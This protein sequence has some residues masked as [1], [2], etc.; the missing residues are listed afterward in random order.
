MVENAPD[1]ESYL[2]GQ[3]AVEVGPHGG[4]VPLRLPV[5]AERQHDRPDL[6]WAARAPAG[7]RIRLHV[8]VGRVTIRLHALTVRLGDLVVPPQVTVVDGDDVRVHTFSRFSVLRLGGEGASVQ[9]LGVEAGEP[10]DVVID[11]SSAADPLEVWLSPACRMELLSVV[12]DSPVE[13]AGPSGGPVWVHYGSSISHGM[14][15]PPHLP[16]P[17]QVARSTGWD[18]RNLSFSG[19][20]QLDPFAGRVVGA[21]AA[22]VVTAKIGINVVNADVMRESAFLP[23]VHGFVDTVRERLPD[24]P[25]VLVS[26]ISCPIHEDTPGPVVSDAGRW[27]TARRQVEGDAGA[28][29]L[30]RTRELLERVVLDRSSDDPNLHH[31]DGRSL[32]GPDDVGMLGDDLHPDQA[33]TDLIADR[34]PAALRGALGGA[35][36]GAV[37]FRTADQPEK[38]SVER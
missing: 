37:P 38:T 29:T 7:V 31:L 30:R 2:V 12:A 18:L 25:I 17:V 9:S 21:I 16:W 15:S 10:E 34:F 24:V 8:G 5:W 13:P 14:G 4:V 33:G 32:F 28:L 23:A 11:R 26:A 3:V 19:N 1:L 22:D 20:A 35:L 6:R 27:R 36:G